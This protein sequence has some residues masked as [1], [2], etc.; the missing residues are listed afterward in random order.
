M[1]QGGNGTGSIVSE[2]PGI[3][4]PPTCTAPFPASS[5]VTLI[6]SP[7][8]ASPFLSWSSAAPCRPPTHAAALW[9]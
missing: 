6:A 9:R 3:A 5:Q 2:P 7:D 4:C 1:I 8:A